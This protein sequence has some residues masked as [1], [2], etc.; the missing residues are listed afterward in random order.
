M[1]RSKFLLISTNL[2]AISSFAMISC[3]SVEKPQKPDQPSPQPQP[4]PSEI[5]VNNF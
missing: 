3:A 1:K 5:A 4:D 2:V